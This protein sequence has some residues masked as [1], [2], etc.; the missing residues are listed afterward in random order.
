[1]PPH[2]IVPSAVSTA[3]LLIPALFASQYS[4]GHGEHSQIAGGLASAFHAGLQHPLGG[5][6]HL[7][8]LVLAGALLA[9]ASRR[10]RP[11]RRHLGFAALGLAAFMLVWSLV[12]YS[13]SHW[14]VF[15]LGYLL[16]S[17]ATLVFGY[18][19]AGLARVATAGRARG[20]AKA[21]VRH[22]NS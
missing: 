8:A 3:T 11:G 2:R 4:W 17:L 6:D 7:V 18:A 20:T 14:L 13:G 12:H 15:G 10:H 9:L 19:V 21:E 16:S 22:R 5:L 1:M